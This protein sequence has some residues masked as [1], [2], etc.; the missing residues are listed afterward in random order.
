[1]ADALAERNE[2]RRTPFLERAGV[3]ARDDVAVCDDRL[4]RRHV[5]HVLARSGDLEL[6][7]QLFHLRETERLEDADIAPAE[8]DL[9]P[10]RG[11]LRRRAERVMVVVEL[12]TA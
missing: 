11:E 4:E 10:L 9:V 8:I 5:R 6:G 1:M 7:R 2:L 12:F 3:G